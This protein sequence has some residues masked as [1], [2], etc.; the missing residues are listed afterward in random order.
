L[1]PYKDPEKQKK[2]MRDYAARD[3][4]LLRKTKEDLKK[5]KQEEK[6]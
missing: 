2:Y 1:S 5:T 6:K 3:R 4:E